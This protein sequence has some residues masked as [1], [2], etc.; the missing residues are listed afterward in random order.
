MFQVKDHVVYGN[1]GIC[2]V[3]AVGKLN[4]D[5]VDK[6]KIYYTCLL[7]TSLCIFSGRKGPGCPVIPP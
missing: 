6:D 4:M 1:H 5:A 2:E 7:Y 3:K